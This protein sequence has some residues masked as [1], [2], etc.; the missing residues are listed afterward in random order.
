LWK[1]VEVSAITPLLLTGRH[2]FRVEHV[3]QLPRLDCDLL[4]AEP[5]RLIYQ[6][7]DRISEPIGIRCFRGRADDGTHHV[8]RFE[9]QST[10]REPIREHGEPRFERGLRVR[11][12][13]QHLAD[14]HQRARISSGRAREALDQLF[15]RARTLALGKT[16]AAK[17][18]TR[19]TRDLCRDGCSADVGTLPDQRDVALC[20]DQ[21]VVTQR[22][23]S[24]HDQFD[25]KV[26][27]RAPVGGGSHEAILP[28]DRNYVRSGDSI[29]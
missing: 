11:R 22:L 23:D 6:L 14:P 29:C 17:L 15:W 7:A 9:R 21:L 26:G 16:S 4:H 27:D 18:V 5:M 19:S 8:R 25:R 1:E 20:I 28:E 10:V 12:H 24:G 2:T 3:S 13:R